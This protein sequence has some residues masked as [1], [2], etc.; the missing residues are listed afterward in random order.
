MIW[1][2]TNSNVRNHKGNRWKKNIGGFTLRK[3]NPPVYEEK[4]RSKMSD[5]PLNFVLS[6][7]FLALP[8]PNGPTSSNSAFQAI[9][10]C[11]ARVA[12][13]NVVVRG[14]Q[15]DDDDAVN[16]I[17]LA[18]QCAVN[19]SSFKTYYSE[20]RPPSSS[21]SSS[22]PPMSNSSVSSS[23]TASILERNRRVP[24]ATGA[25]LPLY[26][27]S[28]V[29]KRRGREQDSSSSWYPLKEISDIWQ[30]EYGRRSS[31]AKPS[32]APYLFVLS[33]SCNKEEEEEE[34]EEERGGVRTERVKRG[35]KKKRINF[36]RLRDCEF[37][38]D[39]G[40]QEGEG[41]RAKRRGATTTTATS[42][43]LRMI[44]IVESGFHQPSSE[45]I[46]MRRRTTSLNGT[47]P[48]AVG[49][50][51]FAED[52][53]RRGGRAG[54][55]SDEEGRG[56][57]KEEIQNDRYY[58][59]E[60][61]DF[62]LLETHRSEAASQV[63]EGLLGK[64]GAMVVQAFAIVTSA[65]EDAP[66]EYMIQ[67]L[68]SVIPEKVAKEVLR[69]VGTKQSGVIPL[70]AYL[71]DRLNKSIVERLTPSLTNVITPAII[72]DAHEPV[73]RRVH[74]HLYEMLRRYIPEDV[75]YKQELPVKVASKVADAL[76]SPINTAVSHAV[77]LTAT[78]AL[79]KRSGLESRYYETYYASYYADYHSTYY[80]DY[81]DKAMKSA[82]KMTKGYPGGDKESWKTN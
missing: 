5:G 24:F 54:K 11:R 42:R 20:Y 67:G 36:L 22:Q 69:V 40:P 75:T 33:D 66:V 26:H 59:N 19:T 47:T 53:G 52:G 38:L 74:D 81:Y 68:L 2:S 1:E 56:N 73:A 35:G 8:D 49:K 72:A 7:H 76:I 65:S 10:M 77:T 70:P 29:G 80:S 4:P 55:D 44:R 21:L 23:S 32:Q 3:S 31:T 50:D 64:L 28:R 71:E 63:F 12:F 48:A 13:V 78:L 41:G 61:D 39:S 9:P 37:S 34:E 82:Q 51:D 46:I 45:V 57:V 62:S 18:V 17:P 30:L 79:S 25:L 6:N 14:R 60:R 16:E 27:R 43:K 58:Y 15:D